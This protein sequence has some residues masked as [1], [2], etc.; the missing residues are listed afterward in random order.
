MPDPD[1]TP[2]A[3][4]RG[5]SAFSRFAT[6]YT[7]S[8]DLPLAEALV[9]IA[10]CLT[11]VFGGCILFA[12]WGAGSISVCGAIASRFWRAAAVPPLVLLFL[13]ALA[14]LMMVVTGIEGAILPKR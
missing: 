10:G 14:A 5:R 12:V 4:A 13:A 1:R 6:P 9:A 11:R 3:A 8:P 7:F 2:A